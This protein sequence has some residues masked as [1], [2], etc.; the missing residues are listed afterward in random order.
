MLTAADA[1]CETSRDGKCTTPDGYDEVDKIPCEE[2]DMTLEE[3]VRQ[4]SRMN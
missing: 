2:H 4:Q 1:G 3:Q